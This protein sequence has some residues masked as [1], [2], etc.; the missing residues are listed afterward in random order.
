MAAT[1]TTS[2]DAPK[3][4]RIAEY[5]ERA[6]LARE[7]RKMAP[8]T[9]VK[10]DISIPQ[11]DLIA[12]MKKQDA[13]RGEDWHYFFGDSRLSDRYADAGN[14]PAIQRGEQ[15]KYWGDP[16][17][18][19]PRDMHEQHM[20]EDAAKS[21]ALFQ[22]R[23]KETKQEAQSNKTGANDTGYKVS[24]VRLGDLSKPALVEAD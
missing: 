10:G 14:E 19:C 6:K 1:K 2:V 4:P 18:R 9:N 8:L 24:D 17:W 11:K 22:R 3:D 16:L 20:K 5:V 23:V 13:E 12:Q 21:T 15:V 7:Q